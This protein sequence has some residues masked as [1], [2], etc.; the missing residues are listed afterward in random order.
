MTV[1]RSFVKVQRADRYPS[2]EI[3]PGMY[4]PLE[5]ILLDDDLLT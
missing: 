2:K 5:K 4:P 3:I 1:F